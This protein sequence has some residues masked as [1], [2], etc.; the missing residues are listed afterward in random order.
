MNR[1]DFLKALGL[2]T[3]VSAAQ[4]CNIDDNVYFTPIE[5]IVPYVTRPEQTTPGTFSQFA[6]S[7]GYGPHAWPVVALHRE[8]RVTNVGANHAA[9][10]PPAVTSA[11]Y[12]AVQRHYAPDRI[13]A[14]RKDGAP[15][16][17]KQGTEL[18]TSAARKARA[19]GKQIAWIGPYRSGS[20]ADLLDLVTNGHAVHFEPL[21]LDAERLAAR[22]LFGEDE[23]LRF[24]LDEATFVLSFGAPFLSD[25]WGNASVRTGFSA[26]RAATQNRA[27]ARF[28]AVTP[29]KDQTTANADDWYPCT[30]GSEALVALAV[31]SLVAEAR[32]YSGPGAAMLAAANVEQAASASGLSADAIRELATRFVD[33]AVALPGG[34]NGASGAATRL[35]GAVY[36]LNHVA[37]SPGMRSGGYPGP[38]HSQADVDA[39]VADMEAG[40]VG[41]LL[42]DDLDLAAVLP[43][44]AFAAA[45]GKVGTVVSVSSHQNETNK[46]ITTV[47]PTHD[48]F[49]DWGDEEPWSGMT[50]VRQPGALPLGDTRSLGDLLLDIWRAVDAAAAPQQTW[51]DWLWSGW[52]T[53]EPPAVAAAPEGAP[54]EPDEGG[55]RGGRRRRRREEREAAAT[56][57]AP[58]V[59]VAPVVDLASPESRRALQLLLQRGYVVSDDR[60]RKP[61]LV[62]TMDF[63]GGADASGDGS[64]HLMVY[65]H[66]FKLDGR[67]ANEPWAN[68]TP[69]PMTG[70]MWDSWALLHPETAAG[71]G[72]GD[73]DL[74]SIDANGKTLQIGVEV[75]PCVAPGVVAIA[76]GGGRTSA[77]GRYADGVG[78]NVISVLAPRKDAAGASVFQGAKVTVRSAG[79]RADLVSTFGVGG[80]DQQHRHFARVVHADEW[81]G[82]TEVEEPGSLTGV[83]TLA[84]DRRLL[85]KE[86]E[87]RAQNPDA[88]ME[89]TQYVDLY[90]VPD[91]PTYRFALTVDTNSCTGCGAC[92][93]ACYAENNIPV[94]GKWKVRKSREMS[95]IRIN[96]YFDKHSSDGSPSVH[97][98]PMMCQQCAHAPCESV[99]PVL[100]TYHTIDGLNAMVYNRCVGTRYCAN[101]CPYSIRRFNYH[102]YA[103]P[104]PFNLQLNPDVS[105]RTMGVMEK[106]T[107]CVQRIRRMKAAYRAEGFTHTVPDEA[108]RQLTACAE[109]CPSQAIT[110]GNLNDPLSTPHRTRK[111]G[112]TYT[113]LTEINTFPAVN[114]L[115]RAS[116]HVNRPGHGSGHASADGAG[117]HE[118]A[119]HG[120]GH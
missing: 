101:A 3:G 100:A 1:R 57:D 110:F 25:A 103:W 113:Q 32:K 73:N 60:A 94:V 109:A 78:V 93:V 61:E 10:V 20:L 92:V 58:P 67:F 112:R 85:A 55:G 27:V 13:T 16:D 36:L 88:E 98:V 90:P 12:L 99:C 111:T 65:A 40:K 74:L 5:Q 48:A 33:G 104:E 105:S 30:P 59:A 18:L 116:F 56:P 81:Q 76:L 50:V 2:G 19:E 114:Y 15:M 49:E 17:W 8:G 11:G 35:A 64:H 77:S 24:V 29:L 63:S 97:F 23:S 84:M 70:Q 53:P 6:T 21:G 46:D 102:T 42:V 14:P 68:E 47:L 80:D 71:L 120:A 118:A 54:V 34:L 7:V 69:D 72:V 96:R 115:A 4:A 37:R 39:L 51:R 41:L 95:W 82:D 83:H 38:I 107:F 44:G 31:A 66:P 62:G 28:A 43:G 117:S 45:L 52:L 91:H 26:A 22:A 75:H 79:S 9:P 86:A 87:W 106:C 119:P 89:K 108:L